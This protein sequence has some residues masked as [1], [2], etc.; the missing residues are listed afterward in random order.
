MGTIFHETKHSVG[1]SPM[2]SVILT[3]DEPKLMREFPYFPSNAEW[4]SIS[5]VH[6]STTFY[7]LQLN[8]NNIYLLD[9]SWLRQK[10]QTLSE[11]V[12]VL[13]ESTD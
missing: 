8:Q 11:H 6:L 9:N 10:W 4:C 7:F 2:E 5:L 3:S 1:H 13:V 12:L